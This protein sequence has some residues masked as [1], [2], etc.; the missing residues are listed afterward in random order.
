MRQGQRNFPSNGE[1]RERCQPRKRKY[2]I[3]YRASIEKSPM[4]KCAASRERGYCH[5]NRHYTKSWYAHK[6]LFGSGTRRRN[7]EM[8][9]PAE[10]VISKWWGRAWLA[11]VVAV[12]IQPALAG[13]AGD[14]SAL[15]RNNES[16]DQINNATPARRK[17]KVKND[18]PSPKGSCM[19]Y[20]SNISVYKP[21]TTSRGHAYWRPALPEE[22][23][24]ESGSI[25]VS[26]RGRATHNFMM[27]IFHGILPYLCCVMRQP[28]WHMHISSGVKWKLSL[29]VVRH[30]LKKESSSFTYHIGLL[31]R[32][33][34]MHLRHA[35]VYWQNEKVVTLWENDHPR[36]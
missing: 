21:Q 11:G 3:A 14:C 4:R 36:K 22:S 31:L 15:Q 33:E 2:K 30:L 17:W 1:W 28:A 23:I 7:H 12:R 35:L 20:C 10:S 8:K 18:Q 27:A 5:R 19:L 25:N 26:S 24:K 13:K 16:I 9:K 6:M 34:I 32:V 29:S